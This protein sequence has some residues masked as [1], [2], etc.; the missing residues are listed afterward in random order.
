MKL[1]LFFSFTFICNAVAAQPNFTYPALVVEY[2]S[3][4]VFRNLKLVPVKR[5]LF[6]EKIIPPGLE[7]SFITLKQGMQTGQIKVKE[8]SNYM[9][10]NINVLLIENN[11]S[12]DLFI[13]SGEIVTGGRQDRIF[14][15][16]TILS[17]NKI[18]HT[19]PVYCIEEYRWSKKEKK[20]LY[21][22]N[23]GS[24]LQKNI[25][26][27]HNQTK[28][29]SEVRQ[30]LKINNL[31]SSSS[32]AALIKSK[33][34]TDSSNAYIKYFLQ[35]LKQSDSSLVGIIAVSGNKILGADIFASSFLFYQNLNGLLE[36]FSSEAIISRSNTI[37]DFIIEKKYADEMLAPQTQ[38]AFLQKKGKRFYY[39]N[40]LLQITGY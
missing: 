21:G 4:I 40:V 10:D 29:W 27:F 5:I 38:P 18:Q 39:K 17:V 20:F 33:K 9:V 35:K 2:D 15:I 25:D 22:G 7:G 12:K 37:T 14:A 23:A 24:S 19:V 28:L 6:E 34:I 13:K 3:S 16:D 8:R 11:S 30:I 32:Y 26:S 36:K 1:L 31:T